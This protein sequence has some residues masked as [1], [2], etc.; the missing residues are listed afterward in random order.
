MTVAT[1][2]LAL[3][4]GSWILVGVCLLA[5]FGFAQA[6]YTRGNRARIP[7]TPYARRGGSAPGATG[8]GEVS[9]KDPDRDPA[10]RPRGT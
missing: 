5:V 2:H 6:L 7:E 1:Q 8:H 10:G 4:D 3:A 9:G